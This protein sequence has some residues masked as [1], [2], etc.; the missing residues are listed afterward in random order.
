MLIAAGARLDV[1][2]QNGDTLI[3]LAC[4]NGQPDILGK[5]HSPRTHANCSLNLFLPPQDCS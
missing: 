1:I 4:R 5:E 3:L 2:N